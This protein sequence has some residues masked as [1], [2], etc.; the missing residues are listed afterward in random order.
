[1]PFEGGWVGC[2]KNWWCRLPSCT[3]FL[4]RGVVAARDQDC[5]TL[6][7]QQLTK[8][9]QNIHKRAKR[10]RIRIFQNSFKSLAFLRNFYNFGPFVHLFLVLRGKKRKKKSQRW[11]SKPFKKCWGFQGNLVIVISWFPIF[12]FLWGIP[13]KFVVFWVIPSKLL[14]APAPQQ[15]HQQKAA[16]AS[17]QQQQQHHRNYE[18]EE[19]QDEEEKNN[20]KEWS[21]N[22]LDEWATL[23][24]SRNSHSTQPK[25][26][27]RMMLVL[28]VCRL[29]FNFFVDFFFIIFLL[30]VAAMLQKKAKA[31]Q[32]PS[33]I[34]RFY[35]VQLSFHLSNSF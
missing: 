32:P 4:G 24:S 23:I 8:Y 12:P 10:A 21:Q 20:L 26:Y 28:R 19:T 14:R 35:G 2:R 3:N 17:S 15:H 25:F 5:S 7:P 9:S 22:D 27:I 29:L 31:Q 1:M 11:K 30:V 13:R 18:K 34:L 6:Y 33:P 16:A